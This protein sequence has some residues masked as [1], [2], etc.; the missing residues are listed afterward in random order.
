M[1]T[2]WNAPIRNPGETDQDYVARLRRGLRRIEEA[3]AD[4]AK[5]GTPSVTPFA[6]MWN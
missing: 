3:L 5:S 1:G 2:S 4:E 6:G